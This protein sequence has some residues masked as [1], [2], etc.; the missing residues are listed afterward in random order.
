MLPPLIDSILT[1]RR[2]KVAMAGKFA[3]NSSRH[4]CT[5]CTCNCDQSAAGGVSKSIEIEVL[6]SLFSMT[7]LGNTI[8]KK[9]LFI[10]ALSSH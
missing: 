7:R 3:L 2:V 1:M 9:V 8:K 6:F 10:E 4:A 5:S